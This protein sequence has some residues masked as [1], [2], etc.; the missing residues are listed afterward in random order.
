MTT[1]NAIIAPAIRTL[2]FIRPKSGWQ[3]IDFRELWRYRDLLIIF[4]MR[5]IQVRYKQ[6]MLG[7][8]WAIIQ[9]L[10]TAGVVSLLFKQLT[11]SGEFI[12]TFCAMLPW[13]LFAAS[14]TQSGSSLINNQRL[15]TKVYFPRLIIPLSGVLGA[16]VD[17]SIA[18]IALF[19][20]MAVSGVI[21]S[22]PIITLPAFILFA[23]V[24]AMSIGL[25]LAALGALYRDF[26]HVI[27]FIIQL[28]FFVS[29][30]IYSAKSLES[31]LPSWAMLL[32]G[33]NPMTGVIEGFRW[34][35]IPGASAP[36]MLLIP[37]LIVTF[38]LLIGGAYYFRYMERWFADVI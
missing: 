23:V 22:W 25:W 5:E 38:T 12:S 33:L 7:V 27:P 13:Q 37:S 26:R 11:G 18:L 15:I 9:P 8:F 10:A 28:G 19:I 24:A 36:G 32:Y 16:L 6:T 14:L 31:K 3:A 34:A 35:L 29:P 2:T 17:F 4:T 20:A 30:V 1:V 21:P